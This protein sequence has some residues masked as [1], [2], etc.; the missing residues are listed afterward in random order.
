MRH[1]H[2]RI[3]TPLV[4]GLRVQPAGLAVA[5]DTLTPT[6][7]PDLF[8]GAPVVISGRFTGSAQ[9][10]VTVTGHDGWQAT[11]P[12][13]ASRNPSLGAVWARARIR[14]LEDRYVVG[15]SDGD[16]LEREI[17]DTSLRF[18]VL[19]RF[20]AFVAVDERVVNEGGAVHRVTQPVEHPSGWDMPAPAP[21]YQASA[22][23]AGGARPLAFGGV[24]SFL[25]SM[26]ASESRGGPAIAGP[27]IT[28]VTI[29]AF[30]AHELRL[31]RDGRGLG[32]WERAGLLT[33]LAD[34][35]RESIA[36]WVYA[37]ESTT[38]LEDLAT[39]LSAPTA[40]ADEVERRWRHAVGIL[41]TLTGATRSRRAFWKR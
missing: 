31:L 33:A 28:P 4:T 3:A 21:M 22:R 39:E 38:V 34:R 36:Q 40:D 29:H 16:S 35:I 37:G 32:V 15:G 17:V 1:I 41:E 8:A 14:D 26:D 25:E 30:A 12:A 2:R 13:T 9:G 5:G 27:A 20:T 6:P 18:G 10:A 7:L 24:D 19:S 11:V 23:T